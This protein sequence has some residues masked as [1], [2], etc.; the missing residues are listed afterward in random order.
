MRKR[1]RQ[2]GTMTRNA[3]RVT[4]HENILLMEYDQAEECH[5]WFQSITDHIA[6]LAVFAVSYQ[7]LVF[8]AYQQHT[9]NI[10]CL[11]VLLF[12]DRRPCV[13]CGQTDKGFPMQLLIQIFLD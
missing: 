1:H 10:L 3:N 6:P 9:D 11:Y 13:A 4:V 2:W 12:T 7:T 5:L 8:K